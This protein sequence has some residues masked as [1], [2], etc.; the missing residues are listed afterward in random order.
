MVFQKNDTK[1][2]LQVLRHILCLYSIKYS[3]YFQKNKYKKLISKLF[4][5]KFSTLVLQFLLCFKIGS[6]TRLLAF[7]VFIYF[8]TKFQIKTLK[9]KDEKM[10]NLEK[11]VEAEFKSMTDHLD[12][13]QSEMERYH[14]RKIENAAYSCAAKCTNND[15]ASTEETRNCVARCMMPMQRVQQLF[16]KTQGSIKVLGFEKSIAFFMALS[17][18][19]HTKGLQNLKI[20]LK[21]PFSSSQMQQC[22]MDCESRVKTMFGNEPTDAQ[23]EQARVQYMECALK[24]PRDAMPAIQRAFEQLKHDVNTMQ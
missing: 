14:F 13:K 21:I 11:Q 1:N 23:I 7:F 2:E 3:F 8:F 18:T 17:N 12:K 9:K 22:M 15:R 5:L 16:Q 10:A 6:G 4:K 20:G 19:A 24:C